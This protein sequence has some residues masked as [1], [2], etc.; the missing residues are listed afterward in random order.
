MTLGIRLRA[1]TAP[2]DVVAEALRDRQLLVV[3]DNCEHV[4]D[5]AAE[6]IDRLGA[7]CPDVGVLATSRERLEVDGEQVVRL[8]PMTLDGTAGNEPSE[9]ALLFCDRAACVLGRFAPDPDELAAV[10]LICRR[11]D[12]LPLAIEL[13]AARLATMS[14]D[15][16]A[17]RLD[18]R[19]ALLTRRR[20]AEAR[21]LSLH[22]TVAWSYDLLNHGERALFD[23]VAVCIGGF[24][25]DAAIDVSEDARASEHLEALAERSLLE[26]VDGSLNGDRFDA[27]ETLRQYG[28]HNLVAKGRLD[29]CRRRHLDHYLAFA[30]RANAG[31]RSPDEL[32][33]HHAFVTDW[34]NL[35]RAFATACELDDADAAFRLVSETLWWAV[36]RVRLDLARWTVTAL[37]LESGVKHPLRSTVGAAACTSR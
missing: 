5:G 36:T 19:F 25:A 35:E 14:L 28:H 13:A 1:N 16:L 18:E 33:W 29:G 3:L 30:A 12:G 7:R 20:G 21:H 24:D 26:R 10:E 2:A 4:L 8:P 23:D 32:R 22:A 31:V 6:I 34:A 17:G 37:A 27:L 11:L 15:D 9:A